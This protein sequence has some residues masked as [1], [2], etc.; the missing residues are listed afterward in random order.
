MTNAKEI[1]AA[2]TKII[3]DQH[4]ANNDKLTVDS[5]MVVILGRCG[6]CDR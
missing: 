6:D 4:I 1:R 5:L 3:A 2:V